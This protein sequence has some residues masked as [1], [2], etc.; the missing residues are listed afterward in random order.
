MYRPAC[1]LQSCDER[2]QVAHESWIRGGSSTALVRSFV[3]CC[4]GFRVLDLLIFLALG[5]LVVRS[6]LY[7]MGFSRLERRSIVQPRILP[8]AFRAKLMQPLSPSL[9][10]HTRNPRP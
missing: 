1:S 3:Q 7:R 8:Q 6:C 5:F 4:P 10:D 9:P 2:S